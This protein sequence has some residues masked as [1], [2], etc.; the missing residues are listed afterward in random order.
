MARGQ[1]EINVWK[2]YGCLGEGE[3]LSLEYTEGWWSMGGKGWWH[4]E[5]VFEFQTSLPRLSDVDQQLSNC[6]AESP[7]YFTF[8]KYCSV[9]S[10]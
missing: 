3:E 5:K 8:Y 9:F 1:A 10:K 7:T 4:F 6:S 2:Q